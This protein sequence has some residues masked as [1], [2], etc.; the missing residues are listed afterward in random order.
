MAKNNENNENE[1]GYKTDNERGYN[2]AIKSGGIVPKGRVQQEV[3][4]LLTGN[5]ALTIKQVANRRGTHLQAVYDVVRKLK[6]QGFLEG[7]SFRGYNNLHTAGAPAPKKLDY[8]AQ[9]FVIGI[10]DFVTSYARQT[11]YQHLTGNKGLVFK[12]NTL[13]LRSDCIEIYSQMRFKATTTEECEE[14][15]NKYWTSYFEALQG[16]YGAII[17]KPGHTNIKMTYCHIA[18]LENGIAHHHN[19]IRD[20]IMYTD[21]DTGKIWLVTDKSFKGND[22]EFHGL[23]AI[24][25]SKAFEPH[26]RD[27]RNPNQATPSQMQGYSTTLLRD[28]V[29]PIAQLVQIHSQEIKQLQQTVGLQPLQSSAQAESKKDKELPSYFG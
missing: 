12:G 20:R 1:R 22:L 7:T 9:R 18:M 28:V 15:S 11:Y 6:K 29:P 21:P 16:K 17:V 13:K 19:T 3:L 8:H 10:I 24:S 25:D 4:E 5:E 2:G 14:T 23:S 26:L 27:W